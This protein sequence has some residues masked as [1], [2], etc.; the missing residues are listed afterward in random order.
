[1]N[2]A[3]E[4]VALATAVEPWLELTI[5]A[6]VVVIGADALLAERHERAVP[7][8]DAAIA[9]RT[10][11]LVLAAI[12][13][14]AALVRV[15]GWQSALTPAW[16]FSEVAV[17]PVD[18]MLRDGAFWET[19]QRQLLATHIDVAYEATAVLPVLAG[20]Q[21]LLGPRF[22][23]SVLAGA[24][25]GT[26]AVVVAWAL[27]R[28][29]RS[30]AFGLALAAMVAFSPLQLVWSRLS[31]MCTEGIVHVLV[32]ML[33]GYVAGRR[34]SLVLAVVTG[35][36]AWTSFQQ[37]YAARVC[38]PLAIVAMLAGAQRGMRLGRGL[39]LVLVAALSFGLVHR[40]VH[41]VAFASTF[42][43]SYQGYVGNKGEQ[44]LAELVRQNRDAVVHE[45][46]VTLA[47]YF[48][49]RR[50]GWASTIQ[51][52][53][54][55]NGGLCLLPT[56]LLGAVGLA[57]VLR[58]FRTQWPWF[59]VAALG[60]ALPALSATTAR[61][62]L[63]LDLA[64]CAF[65]AHGL[66]AVVDGLGRR[67]SY[68]TRGRAAIVVAALLGG[69][70]TMA[71]LATGATT[72]AGFGEHIPFGDAGFGDVISCRRCL[73]AARGWQRDIANGDFVVLFDNDVVREN[74]TSP[75]GLD[76][77]GKIAALAAGNGDRFV[78]M[79][80]LMANFDI[81]P[82]LV[83]RMFDAASRSFAEELAA[84]IERTAPARIVWH[85][86]RPT[87]WERW[88]AARLRDAGGTV[89]TFSTPLA[90]HDGIRVVTPWERRD[91]A[92]AIIDELA[93]G[94]GSTPTPAC[95]RLQA[96][97]TSVGSG[98]VFL[99]ATDDP[100]LTAPPEWLLGSW[101][102]HRYA[103]FRFTTWS[104]A[105]GA[106]LLTVPGAS[107]RAWLLGTHGDL[108]A[109]DLPSMHVQSVPSV[110]PGLKT[111][112]NCGA[113][114]GGHWWVIEPQNGRVISTHPA[115][116]AVPPGAWIGIAS[117]RPGEIVLASA[118]QEMLI[119]DLAS[120]SAIAR[121]PAR[122]SPSVRDAVDEC[123]PLAIGDDWI[124]IANLRTSVLSMYDRSGHDLG[125][126]RLDVVVP[127]PRGLSTIGG[128]GHY[129]GVSS[130][131]TVRTFE[132][133]VDAQC[134]ARI[135]AAR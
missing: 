5:A 9:P 7:S 59:A 79:Y 91:A 134:A 35:L 50:T 86:E 17:L 16:W 70:S 110:F 10:E 111:G 96:R 125:T 26:L 23:L 57:V 69:W 49:A 78:E 76:A 20:L 67:F 34:G 42:W 80:G 11:R 75:G 1:M 51:R 8:L 100:G 58:R 27:G 82:P 43:P 81:E 132:L 88:L 130:G 19:W 24:V 45:T 87:T 129:L 41:H 13:G 65:A 102:E 48:T 121:F 94:L 47:R 38:V 72:S 113:W 109:V 44:S 77:Y 104:P 55:A 99:L 122:V 62:L 53:G 15:V 40:V 127:G 92:L 68:A 114:A 22:G 3:R 117:G 107:R 39:V 103:T 74:R 4:V 25:M 124:G 73:D 64:W 66:V 115:A 30:Q 29:M 6:A 2:G 119:Y 33:V 126:M 37:Y 18:K 95:F 123:T 31:A 84:R 97:Q 63:V 108:T 118:D 85:F 105:A 28:R 71:V 131:T 21:R 54:P 56:A 32:A 60:L 98:P 128:A 112:L 14:L 120:E 52:A 61:R 106:R 116:A 133:H 93:I 101:S 46:Q 135:T 90:P 12:V 36:V 83:G 89:E